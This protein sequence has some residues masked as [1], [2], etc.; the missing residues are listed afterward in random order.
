MIGLSVDKLFA[1]KGIFFKYGNVVLGKQI[2]DPELDLKHGDLIL[3][4]KD[5]LKVNF[6]ELINFIPL[7]TKMFQ[8]KDIILNVLDK[9]DID[10]FLEALKG[11]IEEVEDV[12]LVEGEGRFVFD[13]AKIVLPL[14]SP[15]SGYLGELVFYGTFNEKTFLDLVVSLNPLTALIE[16]IA[17]TKR[18][19]EMLKSALLSLSKAMEARARLGDDLKKMK[20]K[21]F[22]SVKERYDGDHEVLELAFYVYDVGLIGIRDDILRKKINEMRPEEYEEYKRHPIYGYE[23]LKNINNLPREVLTATLFHHE[24]LDGSGY[25][26]G[27]AGTEIPDIALLLGF[28]DE[29]ANMALDGFSEDEI[30]EK[31]KGRFPEDLLNEV[32]E[33]FKW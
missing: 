27:K 25:P 18:G 28:I 33:V 4:I 13:K 11:S 31:L 23:I 21:V 2:D 29:V 6:L 22:N 20:Q 8:H 17:L 32:S 9:T 24:R 14:K 5:V 19:T 10:D 16:G 7:D 30:K 1:E 12:Q 26:Y 15:L 3:Q